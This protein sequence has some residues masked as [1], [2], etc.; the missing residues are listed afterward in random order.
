MTRGR[1]ATPSCPPSC[2]PAG[3]PGQPGAGPQASARARGPWPAVTLLYACGLY[4]A[5]QLGKFAALA[6]LFGVALGMSLP[7]VAL[8]ISLVEAGGATLG[9]LGGRLADRLGLA[10]VLRGGLV[11]LVAAGAAEAAAPTG[12]WLL[13]ARLV[14][15][16]GYL[17]VIVTAPVLIVRGTAPHGVRTQAL[18]LTL[19]STFVP[20]GL[21]LGA[22]ASAAMAPAWGWRWAM[23]A[24]SVLGAGLVG[25]VWWQGPRPAA[26]TRPPA[27]AS[28]TPASAPDTAPDSAPASAPLGAAPMNTLPARRLPPVVALAL[29]FGLFAAFEVGLLGLL[30]TLLVQQAGLAAA[31]AGRWTAL[32]AL[33][34]VGGSALAAWLLRRGVALTGPCLLSLGLPPLLLFG[35]FTAQ[36]ALPLALWLAVAINLIGGVFASLAFALLPRVAPD[37][38]TLVRGNGWIAQC[39]ASGSLLGPPLMAQAVHHGGW[40]AAA[41]L[42][43]VLSL[44][45]LP[46]VVRASRRT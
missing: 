12:G 25:L 46:L 2:P 41:G 27:A 4:A 17:G 16:L 34:A 36:P 10:A 26:D 7:L 24:W 20:V 9:F 28:R 22:W 15:A 13:A 1:A 29:A 37:A 38:R 23:A 39:G 18:A 3:S 45:A 44:A 6:P 14:E 42:G 21:A 31:D 19:W 35:V 40:S 33:S 32:A 11:L 30:P 43:L 8:A 5:V